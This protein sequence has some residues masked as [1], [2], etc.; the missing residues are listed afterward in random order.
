MRLSSGRLCAAARGP[1]GPGAGEAVSVLL[2]KLPS[3]PTALARGR[4]VHTD[5]NTET[6]LGRRCVSLQFTASLSKGSSVLQKQWP[7][8]ATRVLEIRVDKALSAKE[9]LLKTRP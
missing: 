7:L 5:S 3:V 4:R 1:V 6:C 2:H 8:K 9:M